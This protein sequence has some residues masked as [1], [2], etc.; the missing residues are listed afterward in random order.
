[1]GIRF[2]KTFYERNKVYE[3]DF[4]PL[5]K[6]SFTGRKSTD[7]VYDEGFNN[8]FKNSA[9]LASYGL[10]NKG[11]ILILMVL[12]EDIFPSMFIF[13]YICF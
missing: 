9:Y 2:W 10:F 8:V 4:S 13:Y 6:K 3:K 1:M 7:T 5:E 12:L 11:L